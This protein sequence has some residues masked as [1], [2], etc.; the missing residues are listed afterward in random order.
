MKLNKPAP[1]LR[2]AFT[3]AIVGAADAII[4]IRLIELFGG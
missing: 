2:L 3:V 1:R 4:V